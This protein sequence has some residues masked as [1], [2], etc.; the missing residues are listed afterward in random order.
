[1]AG[2]QDA[3]GT[4]PPSLLRARC[5]RSRTPWMPPAPEGKAGREAVRECRPFRKEKADARTG[6]LRGDA[7]G[8]R[9]TSAGARR[10]SRREDAGW[11][12]RRRLRSRR[13]AAAQRVDA[14]G[15]CTRRAAAAAV[16][17]RQA[18][19]R[20]APTVSQRRSVAKA[21][22]RTGR[23]SERA[24]R[25]LARGWLATAKNRSTSGWMC[26]ARKVAF[27]KARAYSSSWE[28]EVEASSEELVDG[29]LPLLC[30]MWPT[31]FKREGLKAVTICVG[32]ERRV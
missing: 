12:P 24:S 28:R 31:I 1:M 11:A 7:A 17:P 15:L 2:R 6:R 23:G 21:R 19:S 22:R 4:T 10:D 32:W 3:P 9:R 18:R 16:W 13:A 27:E 26:G 5:A 30:T 14:S 25:H 29:A 8:R 20:G